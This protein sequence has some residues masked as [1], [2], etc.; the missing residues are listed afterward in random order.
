MDRIKGTTQ[1]ELVIISFKK[2]VLIAVV[3]YDIKVVNRW[4][5]ERKTELI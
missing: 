1:I 5:I 2:I 3:K 4:I